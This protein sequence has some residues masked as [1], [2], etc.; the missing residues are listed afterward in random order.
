MT[1]KVNIEF[2]TKQL[3]KALTLKD[4]E[5]YQYNLNINLKDKVHE[6]MV[7]EEHTNDRD[8]NSFID[9]NKWRD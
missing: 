3:E 1:N 6:Q 8:G 4:I 2:L 5:E 7:M 9:D